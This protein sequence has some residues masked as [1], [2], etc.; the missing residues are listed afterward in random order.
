MRPLCTHR[1]VR[2]SSHIEMLEPRRM[3]SVVNVTPVNYLAAIRH[4]SSGDTI[5][6]A[7][8]EYNIAGGDKVQLPGN[9]TYVGNG[10]LFKG[11]GNS[12]INFS[13]TSNSDFSGFALDGVFASA[14]QTDN[15]YFHDNTLRNMSTPAFTNTAMTNS[16][17]NNNTFTNMDG[18]IYGYPL[19][20]NKVDGNR[21]DY[22]IEPVHFACFG[23]ADGMDISGN[24]I[25]HATRIGIELQNSINNLTVTNNYMSDWLQFGTGTDDAHM[26]ISCA[27]AGTGLAPFTDQAQ[28]VNIS[29]NVLIQNGP[30]Q[31]LNVGAKAAI[32]IMGCND[33]NI[34]NNYCW[35]WGAYLLNGAYCAVNSNN[36]V[37]IGGHLYSPNNVGWKP[38]AIIGSG[39][40]RYALNDP[41][42]PAWPG[43]PGNTAAGA[44]ATPSGAFAVPNANKTRNAARVAR[45]KVIARKARAKSKAAQQ[46]AVTIH[47][48]LVR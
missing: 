3:F 45:T 6:F 36:N 47:S 1:F 5:N 27:T 7:P 18:G 25:T 37:V 41:G 12:C 29:G 24:V 22:V 14:D 13:Y 21:F 40:H 34:N 48:V 2:S 11:T 46:F 32:E 31:S 9:R 20:G 8:G 19:G 16:R 28:H 43:I 30:A 4:S 39:D 42:A 35:N 15:L 38:G 33:I 23:T 26:G 17:I 44:N 10:A